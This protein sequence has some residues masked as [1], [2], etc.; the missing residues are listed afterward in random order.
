MVANSDIELDQL[1]ELEERFAK[2]QEAEGYRQ[3]S[4]MGKE[5]GLEEG[6]KL[7]SIE[8]AKK[9]SELGYLHGF[10]MTYKQ[11]RSQ[12]DQESMAPSAKRSNKI[13]DEILRLIDEFPRTN[14][15]D[16][17]EKLANIRVKFR[18]AFV[19]VPHQIK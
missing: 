14:A 1:E 10:T 8:G 3:G 13:L 6:R 19:N 7:G 9:G 4:Q 17:E 16:C 18:Q 15:N 12:D 11:I 5:A 2:E